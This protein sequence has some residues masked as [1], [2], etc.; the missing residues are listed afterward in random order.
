MR[1]LTIIVCALLIVSA[2]QQA[3]AK[4][5][6]VPGDSST[7][8]AGIDGAANGDTVQVAEG[9]YYERISFYGKSILVTSQFIDDGDTV[10]IYNT[11]IDGDP[12]SLGV[13]DT[14]S[15]VRFVC[16]ENPS[17]I[18][19]GFTI[20]KGIGTLNQ[21]GDRR[22]GGIFCY[23]CSATVA[24]NR[25]IDNHAYWGGGMDCYYFSSP[26]IQDNFFSGD[27]T[28]PTKDLAGGAISCVGYSSPTIDGNIITDNSG[29]GI[30]CT[31]YASPAITNNTITY[32]RRY[33]GIA[34]DF[35]SSPEIV[36]NDIR[37][38]SA[39][40]GGGI[41][42]AFSHPL[43]ERNVIA[44]NTA[45]QDGGGI[46]CTDTRD[47]SLDAT[48]V[49][50]TIDGNSAGLRSGGIH[51]QDGSSPTILNN[52]IANSPDGEGVYC[53][54][55]SYPSITYNDVWNNA[56]GNFCDC[57]DGLGDTDWGVNGNGTPCDSF[58]NIIQDPLFEDPGDDDYRLT[59]CSP[60]I[61]AGD[62]DGQYDDPDGTAADQGALYFDLSAGGRIVYVPD[63][64][65]T[66]Q[67][68]IDCARA[69]D[70]VL[71]EDG[72]YYERIDFRGKEILLASQFVIDS[73]PSHIDSTIID[74]D[75]SV[76]ALSDTGSVVI[77]VSGEDST[78]ILR[79]FTIQKGIGT[80][81]QYNDLQGGGIF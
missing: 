68:G 15:V 3:Q 48:I 72:H 35:D 27:S 77:F 40:F 1:Y 26:V 28:T 64:Y 80:L 59:Y 25:I 12:D 55:N 42:C 66:I 34:L 11:I 44:D 18:L 53:R 61:N 9:H 14:A 17:S 57:G 41:Y 56:D 4:T 10:H 30:W 16:G 45:S 58:Y 21:Y 19:Q 75:T 50:N 39:S 51:C 43:I 31:W 7:I 37:E 2:A 78:S 22:G 70:T 5:I 32:N 76:L 29:G 36:G 33:G 79:G 6:H 38:N 81:N 13:A 49:N 24:H 23:S 60:C 71:V 52:I 20:Q 74:G 62:P 46:Y 69:G 73:D 65:P 47:G 67:E 54:N 8:Q 63:D